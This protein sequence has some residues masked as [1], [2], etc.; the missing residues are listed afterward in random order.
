MKVQETRFSL[1]EH[2][3]NNTPV[4]LVPFIVSFITAKPELISRSGKIIKYYWL[5]TTFP[6]KE[7]N[8]KQ[9]KVSSIE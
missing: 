6:V 9:E 1:L 2:T 5:I 7:D 4:L 3:D 8:S